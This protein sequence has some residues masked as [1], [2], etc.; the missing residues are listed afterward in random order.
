MKKFYLFF[1]FMLFILPFSCTK[2][3]AVQ[4][5]D[6][7][8]VIQTYEDKRGRINLIGE[9]NQASLETEPY[10]SWYTKNY[11]NYNPNVEIIEELKDPIQDYEIEAYFGTWCG[12]SKRDVPRF[13]KILDASGYNLNRLQIVAVGNEGDLYKK[14]PNGETNGKDI[15]NVP[16]FIFYKDGEEVNRIVENKM[17]TSLEEDMLKIV[18]GQSYSHKYADF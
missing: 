4:V 10:A 8:V 3:A 18:T 1:A 12:D 17:G 14:S 7:E 6:K 9:M 2:K 16:T 5:P 11:G 15:T 13:Y